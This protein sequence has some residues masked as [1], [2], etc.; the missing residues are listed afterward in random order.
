MLATLAEKPFPGRA[1]SSRSSTTGIRV[2]ASRL[3][4]R[5]E[6]YGRSGQVMTGRYPEVVAALRALPVDH[7]LVDW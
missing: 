3:G 7:F 6:L 1:G 5:V 4:E 2:L